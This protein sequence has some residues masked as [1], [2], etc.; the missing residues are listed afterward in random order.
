[1]LKN[2]DYPFGI[3]KRFLKPRGT[4]RVT[5]VT[6]PVISHETSLNLGANGSCVLCAESVVL[7]N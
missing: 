4:R 1:M 6:N 7:S 5:L 3:F 2:S